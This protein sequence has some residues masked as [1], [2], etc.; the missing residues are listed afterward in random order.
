MKDLSIVKELSIVKAI[1]WVM[2]NAIFKTIYIWDGY[3]IVILI[4]YIGLPNL[5]YGDI[6]VDFS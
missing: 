5:W 1:Q 2:L 4:F 3:E 6:Y